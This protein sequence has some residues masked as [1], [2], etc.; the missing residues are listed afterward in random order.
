MTGDYAAGWRTRERDGLTK[1]LQTDLNARTLVLWRPH[2]EG[3]NEKNENVQVL[4][5][6]FLP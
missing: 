2:F 4:V 1:L 6:V 3:T 5:R